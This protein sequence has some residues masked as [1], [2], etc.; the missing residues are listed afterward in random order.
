MPQKNHEISR[1]VQFQV[2]KK[3][4]ERKRKKNSYFLEFGKIVLRGVLFSRFHEAN[5]KKGH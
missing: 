2:Q 4:K 5:M 1:Q 3:K